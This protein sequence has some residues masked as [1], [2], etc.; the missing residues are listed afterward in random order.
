MNMLKYDNSLNLLNDHK[1]E[2][3]TILFDARVQQRYA[4]LSNLASEWYFSIEEWFLE[5]KDPSESHR[6]VQSVT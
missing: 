5:F 2:N 4:A 3:S 1:L 6:T